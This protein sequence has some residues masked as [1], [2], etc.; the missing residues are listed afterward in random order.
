MAVMLRHGNDLEVELLG[1]GDPPRPGTLEGWERW[2]DEHLT[3]DDKGNANF[4]IESDNKLIGMCG[5]WRFN[6][7]SQTCELGI[8]IGDREYWGRGYGREAIGLLS[9]L[10]VSYPQY[11]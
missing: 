6:S 10:C 9:G 4:G 8:G 2:Y 3:K 5:L 7:H 11:S 1:G